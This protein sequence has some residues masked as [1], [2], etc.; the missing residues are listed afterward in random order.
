[1]SGRS[2]DWSGVIL[3]GGRSTRMGRDK[4]LLDWHGEPLLAHMH[5]L[6]VRAGAHSVVV[7]GAY[8]AFAGIADLCACRGPLG[9]LQAVARTLPDGELLVVPVDMPALGPAALHGLLQHRDRSCSVFAGHRLPMRLRLD[10]AARHCLD[11]LLAGPAAQ[12]SLHA[13]QAA[14]GTQALVPPADA[15]ERFANCNTPAQWA[16]LHALPAAAR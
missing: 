16:A 5:R 1:M 9:G 7:S 15:R 11:R 3:A 12:C 6:L 10:D 14:L 13:L 4:A 2:G 8:P